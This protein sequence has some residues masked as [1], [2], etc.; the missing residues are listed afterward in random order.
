VEGGETHH[1]PCEREKQRVATETS[2]AE[3]ADVLRQVATTVP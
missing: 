3:P 1:E 2:E